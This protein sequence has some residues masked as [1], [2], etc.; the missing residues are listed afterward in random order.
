MP[1]SAPP[2]AASS[3]ATRRRPWLAG[4]DD[5]K[6]EAGSEELLAAEIAQPI[7]LSGASGTAYAFRHALIQD[8]AYQSLLLA[9][10]RQ[11]HGRIAEMLS[12]P[13]IPR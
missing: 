9:R 5:A 6:L 4:C 8:A 11:Y 2:S 10:R 1:R 12:P 13:S 3:I 7:R